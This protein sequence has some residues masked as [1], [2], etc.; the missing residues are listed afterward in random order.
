M[1]KIWLM[2]LMVCAVCVFSACSDDDDEGPASQNPVTD[3]SVPATAEIG[4]EITVTGTGFATNAKLYFKNSADEKTDVTK[5]DFTASGA[6]L[7]IPMS[8]T[9]GEYRLYL[10]QN[11]EW[12]LG[13]ITL[14]AASLPVIGLE[15]P[16]EGW[17]GKKLTIG[18]SGFNSTAKVYLEN[19]EGERT[20]LT[21]PDITSGFVAKIPATVQAGSYKLILV[22]DGGEWILEGAFKVVEAPVIKR[23]KKITT[24]MYMGMDYTNLE[25]AF[26]ELA[27]TEEGQEMLEMYGMELFGK[28]IET[29]EEFKE[30]LEMMT[31]G[32]GEDVSIQEFTYREGNLVN[33]KENE[34]V[35]Y[36]FECTESQIKATNKDPELYSGVKSFILN[37]TDGRVDHSSVDYKSVGERSLDWTFD[38]N[39]YLL[40]S[41][42]IEYGFVDGNLTSVDGQESFEYKDSELKSNPYAIDM[43][44]FLLSGGGYMDD[45]EIYAI[46]LGLN[47]KRSANLPSASALLSGEMIPLIYVKDSDGYV[48]ST[49]ISMDMG[50]EMGFGLPMVMAYT[51]EFEYEVVD[52]E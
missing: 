45:D 17:I 43:A 30:L 27:S 39:G 51:Y 52:Y 16:A 19:A 48:T 20:E 2:L 24:T 22:Q 28:P 7:T 46:L 37:L 23:L 10:V 13:K 50:D 15:V 26:E 18:G 11:G 9:A 3:V 32:G 31:G 29:P 44:M 14:T 5:A 34:V 36:E 25:S 35:V 42:R 33:V 40:S 4:S 38:E 8:L 21:T 41:D 1:K 12:E 6:T 47:G 49:K